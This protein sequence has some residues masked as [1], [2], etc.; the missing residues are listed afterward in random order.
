MVRTRVQPL[1]VRLP[2]APGAT[3]G[4]IPVPVILAIGAEAHILGEAI[5]QPR[6][7]AMRLVVGDGPPLPIRHLLQGV[8]ALG[9][10]IHKGLDTARAFG[11]YLRC[12]VTS[13]SADAS[14]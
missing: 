9:L 7:G 12:H 11:L 6:A 2:I 10:L 4:G 3:P 14:R 5:E 8:K 13:T 1:P